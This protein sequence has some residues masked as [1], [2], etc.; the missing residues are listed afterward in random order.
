MKYGCIQAYRGQFPV[1]L[2]CRVLGVKRSG[3]YAARKRGPGLRAMARARLRLQVRAI[4]AKSKRRYGSPRVHQE[5]R[6]RGSVPDGGRWRASCA[7]RGCGR[8]PGGASS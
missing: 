4:F 7:K 1:A 8:G 5:L 6:R 2:M 3:F